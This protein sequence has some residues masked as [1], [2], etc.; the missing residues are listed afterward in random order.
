MGEFAVSDLDALI[1]RPRFSSGEAS[2]HFKGRR[3]HCT[4]LETSVVYVNNWVPWWW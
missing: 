2:R 1:T 4:C 3:N